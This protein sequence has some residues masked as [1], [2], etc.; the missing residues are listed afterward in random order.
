MQGAYSAY[1]YNTPTAYPGHYYPPQTAFPNA[2]PNGGGREPAANIY[3]DWPKVPQPQNVGQNPMPRPR[4]E[5]NPIPHRQPNAPGNTPMPRPQQL[6]TGHKSQLKSAMKTTRRSV[7]DPVNQL[8]RTR[9]NSDPRRSL[10][11]MTRTRTNS[12][13]AKDIPGPFHSYETPA[14]RQHLMSLSFQIICLCH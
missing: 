13:A 9:T 6:S 14:H 4:Q 3:A 2:Y 12:N 10:N 5:R 1:P 8:Q 11:P 7:S